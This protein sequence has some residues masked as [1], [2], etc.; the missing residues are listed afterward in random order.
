MP[1]ARTPTATFQAP[2]GLEVPVLAES[3]GQ[4]ILGLDEIARLLVDSAL[5]ELRRLFGVTLFGVDTCAACDMGEERFAKPIN[6]PGLLAEAPE[7][8]S[9]DLLTGRM[10]EGV[11]DDIDFARGS[12]NVVVEAVA[13]C[14]SRRGKVG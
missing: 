7:S 13:M 6:L 4:R 3:S 2:V 12:G 8:D 11:V 14:C 10:P 1:I 9:V 5:E